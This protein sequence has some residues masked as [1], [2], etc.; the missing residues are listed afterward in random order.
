MLTPQYMVLGR[1]STTFN[2]DGYITRLHLTFHRSPWLPMDSAPITTVWV[3]SLG[4]VSQEIL[5]LTRITRGPEQSTTPRLMKLLLNNFRTPLILKRTKGLRTSIANTC[6]QPQGCGPYPLY[7]S[8][9]C[10]SDRF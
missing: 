8:T 9:P 2:N 1:L 7:P 10:P 4:G 3:L 5:P 6:L